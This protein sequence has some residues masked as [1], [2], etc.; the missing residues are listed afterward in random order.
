MKRE[1]SEHR[2]WIKHTRIS[3]GIKF[4]LKLT[5]LTF[6]TTFTQKGYF[7]WKTKKASITLEFCMYRVSPYSRTL[8]FQKNFFI[9]YCEES[10]SKMMKNT[11]YFILTALSVL[12]MLKFLSWLF[13]HLWKTA[14]LERW[15]N[16]EIYDVTA[17]NANVTTK[18]TTQFLLD[19]SQ[20]KGK[21]T[22]NIGQWIEH[23]R[24]NIFL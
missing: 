23:P 3:L 16:F 18:I 11:F 8:T 24:R 1:K 10:P 13:G 7:P 15:V 2:H 21:Q 14:W 6:W 5:I 20:I 12:K 4:H 22:T 17:Y 9:I 19:I